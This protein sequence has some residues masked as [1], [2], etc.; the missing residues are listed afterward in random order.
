M[1]SDASHQ[2]GMWIR[3]TPTFV[4]KESRFGSMI[5]CV[6]A[7]R[8]RRQ[9]PTGGEWEI[10]ARVGKEQHAKAIQMADALGISLAALVDRLIAREQTDERGRPTW[11]PYDDQQEE[12]PLKSA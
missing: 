7:V 1:H 5:G 2:P 12:L 9:N 3:D 10:R 6:A 11:W 4:H 8:G